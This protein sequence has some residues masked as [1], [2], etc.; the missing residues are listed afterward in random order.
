[1]NTRFHIGT[2]NLNGDT[3]QTIHFKTNSKGTK[4]DRGF[5]DS[6]SVN[7]LGVIVE[8]HQSGQGGDGIFWK[9]GHLTDS[10]AGNF[11]I[12]CE[13][14]DRYD[15]GVDPKISVSDNND[16]IEV[17][18]VSG[19]GKLHYIRGKVYFNRQIVG[20]HGRNHSPSTERKRITIQP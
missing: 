10:R 7:S 3:S 6:V 5:H 15:K 14:G 20:S 11:A 4:F 17:H 8:A 12:T 16:V 2:V 13:G 1:M 19:E 18:G 9:V